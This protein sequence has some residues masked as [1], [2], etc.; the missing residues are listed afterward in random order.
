MGTATLEEN[1]LQKLIAMRKTV[2][3]ANFLD[4]S[5]AYN[6]LDRD[7]CIDILSGYGV[8][9]RMLRILWTYW[10]WFH[11]AAKVGVHYGPIF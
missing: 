5:K 11:M 3:R 8:D 4:L 9:I 7:R 10:V 2:L 6:A 1:L